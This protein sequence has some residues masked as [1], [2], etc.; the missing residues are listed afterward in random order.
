MVM[1]HEF[2]EHLQVQFLAWPDSLTTHSILKISATPP[3]MLMNTI[4]RSALNFS[5]ALQAEIVKHS[6]GHSQ[7]N[8]NPESFKCA[9]S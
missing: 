1:L 3:P 6:A 9:N 8:T 4:T 5:P 7:D 2:V